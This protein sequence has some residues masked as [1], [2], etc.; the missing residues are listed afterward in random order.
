[1][2]KNPYFVLAFAALCW[3]GNHIVGRAIAGHFPPLTQS[4]DSFPRS[5]FG[6]QDVQELSKTGR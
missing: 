3:S 4:A 6:S 5:F 1:M 2:K